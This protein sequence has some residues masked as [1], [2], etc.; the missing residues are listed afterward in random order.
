MGSAAEFDLCCCMDG[1]SPCL[2][3]ILDETKMRAWTD[4]NHPAGR[5]SLQNLCVKM[6]SRWGIVSILK[7]AAGCSL[8]MS[9]NDVGKGHAMARTVLKTCD[10]VPISM[11]S[12]G[13]LACKARLDASSIPADRKRSFWQLLSNM[14]VVASEA[15]RPRLT[16]AGWTKCG[17]YPFVPLLLMKRCTLWLRSVVD[18][19]LTEQEKL[20]VLNGLPAM[21]EIAV[22]HGRV[23]DEEIESA[24]PFLSRY[25]T[26]LKSDLGHL[27]TNRDRCALLVHSDYFASRA[28]SA[29]AALAKNPA[30][31]HAQLFIVC[32]CASPK[33]QAAKEARCGSFE[34]SSKVGGLGQRQFVS[35]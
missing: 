35:F 16:R 17:Y 19:G 9:P 31:R 11:C 22:Q 7:W 32:L 24:F 5:P 10:A 26:D 28:R 27:A 2:T 33:C 14:P 4:P 29:A 8:V 12:P 34:T 6:K 25:P 15:F 20:S 13:L 23:S 3:A 30:L 18:G 1:D 21:Q